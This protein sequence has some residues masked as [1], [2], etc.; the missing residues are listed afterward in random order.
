[1][2]ERENTRAAE[3]LQED[4]DDT[5]FVRIPI[6]RKLRF[7]I[8]T[9]DKFTCLYCGARAPSVCLEVDHVIPVS[10]GGTNHP[11][12]LVSSCRDC[13]QAKR[14]GELEFLPEAVFLIVCPRPWANIRYPGEPEDPS[15]EN[16]SWSV[17]KSL[18]GCVWWCNAEW[19]GAVEDAKK[20][21]K[22]YGLDIRE[23]A[24]MVD[25]AE[26]CPPETVDRL[27]DACAYL[28]EKAS[29]PVEAF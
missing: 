15:Q 28:I 18:I 23:A 26:D 5:P 13:N 8:L 29:A 20:L 10:K 2:N 1:V 9:R 11:S 12:N 25:P 27:I 6:P 7:E 4:Y 14:D 22:S 21:M 3:R 19:F 16:V 17:I 24:E